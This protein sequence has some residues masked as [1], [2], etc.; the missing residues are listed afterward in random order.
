MSLPLRVAASPYPRLG[1]LDAHVRRWT[2]SRHAHP[3]EAATLNREGEVLAL[4]LEPLTFDGIAERL[5]PGYTRR[6]VEKAWTA[7][8][9]AIPLSLTGS[10]QVR[11]LALLRVALALDP[12]WCE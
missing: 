11:R 5:G 10:V 6:H 4:L 2:S 3:P 9:Y 8:Q 7:I 12:C 1:H